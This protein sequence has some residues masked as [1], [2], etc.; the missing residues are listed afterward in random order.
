MATASGDREEINSNA[1]LAERWS[2]IAAIGMSGLRCL[3]TLQGTVNGQEF[4][5]FIRRHLLPVINPF[6]GINSHSVV[7]MGKK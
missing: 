4:A 3:H 5:S 1:V 2:S 6:N 7:I